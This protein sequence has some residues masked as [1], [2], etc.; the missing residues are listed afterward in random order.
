MRD[1]YY[2]SLVRYILIHFMQSLSYILK[3]PFCLV[4]LLENIND[5]FVCLLIRMCCL[6][7]LLRDTEDHD[8]AAAMSHFLNC[9]FGSC[10]AFGGKLITNLT[11]SRTPKKACPVWLKIKISATYISQLVSSCLLWS[12]EFICELFL[13]LGSIYAAFAFL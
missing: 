10:Q 2:V 12:N 13:L 4:I 9:L 11:Q 8:L 6:Q 5:V 7:D 3:L 1:S